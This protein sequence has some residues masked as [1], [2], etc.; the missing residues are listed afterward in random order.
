MRSHVSRVGRATFLAVALVFL[1]GCGVISKDIDA[2]IEFNFTI[3]THTSSYDSVAPI[4][5]NTEPTRLAG[6][7]VASPSLVGLQQSVG[8]GGQ[9]SFAPP[10]GSQYELTLQYTAASGQC[11]AKGTVVMKV[12]TNGM[13]PVAFVALKDVL[14]PCPNG[15]A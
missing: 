10:S 14:K 9:L 8:I 7:Q 11:I 2:D 12:Q 4:D 3:E 1:A 15:P 6:G 13:T 5:P